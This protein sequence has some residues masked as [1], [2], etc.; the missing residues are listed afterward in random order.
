[1]VYT[2]IVR[3]TS[4]RLA[5]QLQQQALAQQAAAAAPIHRPISSVASSVIATRNESSPQSHPYTITIRPK[6]SSTQIKRLF[7]QNPAKRRIA[8]KQQQAVDEGVIPESTMQ[9]LGLDPKFLSN[10]WNAPVEGE[11]VTT[12]GYPFQVA[13]TKNKP[14]NALGFL[15]VYS[16]HRKD[17][18]RVTTR[19]KKISGDK[20]LF[21]NELR[22]ALKIPIPKNP[23][24]DTIRIR[25]GGTIEI[26]GN[27]VQEVKTWL[28]GLGF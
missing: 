18:A 28:A 27:R 11:S 22:A 5:C 14:N 24:D 12:E 9:P 21:L 3:R 25:T 23:R 26:K 19:I 13:R 16:E 20:D 15:P 1:M 17:G 4:A 8:L 6:H 10:G 7:K 2:N